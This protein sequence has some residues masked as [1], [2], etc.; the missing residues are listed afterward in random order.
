MYSILILFYFAQ[1]HSFALDQNKIDWVKN[2]AKPLESIFPD[3]GL[4]DMDQAFDSIV[5][6]SKVVSLGEAAHAIREA[7]IFRVRFLEYLVKKKGFRAIALESGFY[8]GQIANRYIHGLELDISKV[9]QTGFT[10]GMGPWEETKILLNWMRQYNK[11]QKRPEDKIH[12]YGF[13][14]PLFQ[15][16]IMNRTP[17]VDAPLEQVL[18][19]MEKV[20]PNY[21]KTNGKRLAFLASLASKTVDDIADYFLKRQGIRYI[22]PDFLDEICSISY[23]N[24]GGEE[25]KELAFL[26]NDLINILELKE[27]RYLSTKKI[28]REE[29][30][31]ALQLA[32]MSRSTIGNLD[33]RETVSAFPNIET[34][35]TVLEK[36]IYPEEKDLEKLGINKIQFHNTSEEWENYFEGR[37][38]RERTMALNVHWLVNKHKKVLLYA[39]NGH[40]AKTDKYNSP[41]PLHKNRY[42]VGM[43]IYLS[44][45]YKEDYVVICQSM[46]RFVNGEGKV[47]EKY[48]GIPVA[49]T[50]DTPDCLE[51]ILNK[52]SHNLFALDLRTKNPAIKRW[53]DQ[54]LKGRHVHSFLTINHY[55]SFDAIVFIRDMQLGVSEK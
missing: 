42:G 40:V 31:F 9:L 34:L 30:D 10:H 35:K 12:F 7:A 19:L 47:M 14:L 52:S 23:E 39:H 11:D 54:K 25:K 44:A 6:E 33:F 53:L 32:K 2:N 26:L 28:T 36:K 48:H 8:E 27:I 17:E 21:Y 49:K 15:D 55:Q 37:N 24:L 4:D 20:D 1:V 5:G 50:D 38:G 46:D 45:K 13:D 29:Y 41:N 16:S 18:A 22:D 3:K 43:G 51:I